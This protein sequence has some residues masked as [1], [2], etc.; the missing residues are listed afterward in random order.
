MK[1]AKWM[2]WEERDK[3][4]LKYFPG[5]YIIA[6]TNKML[7]G[8]TPSWNDVVYIGMT[9]SIGGLSNRWRQ[10]D[11]S[12][13]GKFGHSG[14]KS[15]YQDLGSYKKWRKSLYVAA[16][17]IECDVKEPTGKDYIKMGWVAYF[18]YEAFSQYF[19]EIGKHPKYNKQ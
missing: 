6:V 18:E 15:I 11:R 7:S 5:V 12:I 8:K 13:N 2:R 1:F 17:G 3:Y 4:S 16:M 14:G 19:K 10:L 9:N